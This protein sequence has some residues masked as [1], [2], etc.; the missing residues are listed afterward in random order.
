MKCED[1]IG[2]CERKEENDGVRERK[3]RK[4]RVRKEYARRIEKS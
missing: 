4:K 3:R 1:L 2:I